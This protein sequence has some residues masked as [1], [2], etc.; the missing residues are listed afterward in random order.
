[1]LRLTKLSATFTILLAAFLTLSCSRLSSPFGGGGGPELFPIRQEGK[2]GYINGKGEVV[3]Q[4]QFAEA[5]FFAE[6]LAAV[7]VEY[8]KC[9]YI[10]GAGQFAISPQF[11]RASRFSEGLAAVMVGEKVGYIDKTGKLAINPQ[12][13]ADGGP[14]VFGL[15][16]FSGGL[17]RVKVGD[18]FGFI[19]KEGK[20]VINPQFNYAAPFTEGLAAVTVGGKVGFVGEDGTMV[21]SPQFEDAQPFSN[22][23]AAV[24]VGQQVGYIDKTGKLVI[25]PQFDHA[26]PFS[27]E[28]LALVVLEQKVGFVDKAGKYAINPQ[29]LPQPVSA[30]WETVFTITPEIGRISFS[31]GR[32][33]AQVSE[34][35]TGYIGEDGK[36]VINPRFNLALPFYGGLAL[37]ISK[38]SGPGGEMA[39]VD[40]GGNY[41]WRESKE[42]PKTSADMNSNAGATNVSG[43]AAN[44]TT[45]ATSI[46]ANASTNANTNASGQDSAGGKTGRLTMDANL[47]SDA[48]K[49][50]ASL[51][52]HFR[53]A[54][55]RV[56]EQTSYVRDNEVTTWYKIRVYKYGCSNNT[57]LGCGKNSPGD[58]DEGWVN[59]K[60]VLLD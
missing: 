45:A 31:E 59:A 7:C 10:D 40:V 33:P 49:D 46:N 16:T 26:Y 17:A 15:Y 21:V 11:Q 36:F 42:Q 43:S 39:W 3:V 2:W 48:N 55:V 24:R 41:V 8:G 20:V 51:G 34:G 52:I 60:L 28:G 32:A 47:R 53:D 27:D 9:G 1:V 19:D 57:S 13:P 18:K 38:S 37:V 30:D 14:R 29:F 4:P 58:A 35:N 6:G 12:F 44:V 56:L 23:L 25:N 5:F 22:G 50:S 54:R